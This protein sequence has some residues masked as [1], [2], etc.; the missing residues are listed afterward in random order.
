MGR[1]LQRLR[2]V[3]LVGGLLAGEAQAMMKWA[4]SSRLGRPFAKDPS[5]IKFQGRYLLYYSMPP[6]HKRLAP[7]NAPKGWAIGIAES[8][9]LI[10]WKKVGEILPEQHC[11]Q[12]GICAPCARVLDGRVH[13]F[14]QTY[15]NGPRD[16]ICHAISDDGLRFARDP[17]NPV[18]RPGGNWNA[19]RA[20]DADV[21]EFG[22]RWLLYFATRD[23]AM[24]VQM[25]GVAAAHRRSDFGRNAW[26][27]LGD[28]PV[29][30]PELPWERNCIE[31]PSAL[32]RGDRLYLFYAGGYN[33]EPQQIG[34][35]VSTDGIRFRRLFV[36]QPLLANGQPGQWNS[37]ESGHPG[38]FADDDG[39]VYL[40]YQGNNDR[41][42]TWFISW[43]KLGWQNGR[44][45]VISP[46]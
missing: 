20:I 17:S 1:V 14:Y 10:H 9:D 32:K 18:F 40:F 12:N 33:N 6:Y 44:P 28:G 4:D 34:C 42:H 5:V 19:G 25:L 27:P 16:A 22:E 23:P 13:M 7:P 46:N 31:A 2:C 45:Q 8:R 36:D 35:A 21:V 41:G 11:E 24:R 30:K 43:V 15:G 38:L 3:L 37:C 39:E 29:L 26:Q